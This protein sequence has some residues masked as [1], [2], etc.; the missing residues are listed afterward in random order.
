MASSEYL[1]ITRCLALAG[2]TDFSFCDEES[3]WRGSETHK[4]IELCDLGT[5]NEA[6]VPADLLG[7]LRAHK[8]FMR[9]TGFIPQKIEFEVRDKTLKLRGR[10]DRLGLLR[11]KRT[12]ADFK[13]GQVADAVGLQLCLGGYLADPAVWFNRIAV[14]LKADGNYSLKPF[15]LMEW[16]SDL[17]TALA[18]VRIAR[19]KSEHRLL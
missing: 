12:I 18:C 13:T 9:E 14:Q 11:G 2:V 3:R 5:L 4:M 15:H 8:K 10:V 17:S 1:G 19:W 16:Q 7:Y 6:T